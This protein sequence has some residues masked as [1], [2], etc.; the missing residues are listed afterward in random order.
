MQVNYS[1]PGQEQCL[2]SA[3]HQ[4]RSSACHCF[5]IRTG[6]VH[7]ACLGS[8]LVKCMCAKLHQE[9]TSPSQLFWSR[10]GAV[11]VICWHQDWSSTCHL[12]WTTTGVVHVTCLG[13]GLAKCMC[14]KLYQ[15]MTSAHHQ[16]CTRLPA[17]SNHISGTT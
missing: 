14:A 16:D 5:W 10:T 17:R 1:G 12:F 3:W 11:L 4:D 2:S 13:S 7:V 6:V 9:M 15:E 8:G